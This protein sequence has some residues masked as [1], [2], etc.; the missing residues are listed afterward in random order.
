MRGYHPCSSVYNMSFPLNA[1]KMFSLLLVKQ[2]DYYYF[3][4]YNFYHCSYAY[5]SLRFWICGFVDF[6]K[7]GNIS[8]III[9]NIFVS[10]CLS[11]SLGAPITCIDILGCFDLLSHSF[12]FLY[13]FFFPFFSFFSVCFNW[14]SFYCPVFKFTNLFFY[15]V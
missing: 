7:F 9:A 1:F 11:S 5:G 3:H 10:S 14:D 13:S 4:W 6:V 15:T 12:L 2:V 8:F